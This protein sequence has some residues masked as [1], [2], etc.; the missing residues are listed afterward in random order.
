MEKVS[1][2]QN[3]RRK[4]KALMMC[5]LDRSSARPH[6]CGLVRPLVAPPPPRL[7]PPR[8][9]PPRL[10]PPRLQPPSGKKPAKT[11]VSTSK[12]NDKKEGKH[13]VLF[14][15]RV[16]FTFR[17]SKTNEHHEAAETYCMYSR[18]RTAGNY[19]KEFLGRCKSLHCTV[20]VQSLRAG[21]VRNRSLPQSSS[22]CRT[23]VSPVFAVSSVLKAAKTSLQEF[24]NETHGLRTPNVFKTSN[25]YSSNFIK[26]TLQKS[27]LP[28]MFSKE[29]ISLDAPKNVQCFTG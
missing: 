16:S 2:V 17:P 11:Q 1:K 7:P 25:L 5:K 12:L 3:S 6:V 24:E 4:R 23:L 15:V 9:P 21:M 20:L 26:K 19:S 27:V 13:I 14:Y 28:G 10:P 8:L 18:L 22:V 29:S